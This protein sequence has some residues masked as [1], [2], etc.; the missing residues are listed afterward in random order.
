[1]RTV[2]FTRVTVVDELFAG[3]AEIG[4]RVELEDAQAERYVNAGQGKY[5]EQDPAPAPATESTET[6]AGAEGSDGQANG[7][8]DPQ[9]VTCE[10]CGK[11]FASEVALAAHR[12]QKK[13]FVEE[14]APAE[15]ATTEPTAPPAT[16]E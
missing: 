6:P 3:R 5:V 7:S 12:K 16:T 11:Q 10:R 15:S 4:D 14:A 9:P 8:S 13:H 1:M 2:E